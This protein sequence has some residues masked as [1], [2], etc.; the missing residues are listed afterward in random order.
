MKISSG[1]GKF[2]S[3]VLS[4]LLILNQ[5]WAAGPGAFSGTVVEAIDGTTI[6]VRGAQG[7]R[8][9][10]LAGL[11]SESPNTEIGH[12]AKSVLE[13]E[14]LGKNVTVENARANS[15]ATDRIA[16]NHDRSWANGDSAGKSKAPVDGRVFLDGQDIALLLVG[17]G[18]AW[19][20]YNI[21]NDRNLQNSQDEAKKRQEGVWS[22][23]PSKGRPVATFAQPGSFQEEVSSGKKAY[24]ESTK[25][26]QTESTSSLKATE[27]DE[28]SGQTATYK[29]KLKEEKDNPGQRKGWEK[30]K[31]KDELRKR[32]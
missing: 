2:L 14:L 6:K 29:G 10:R 11:E 4:Q 21:L 28:K 26:G 3:V 20:L 15:A 7:D 23:A 16:Q 5:S 12:Q 24:G 22:A 30:Q 32:D 25:S 27:G 18:L 19:L 1:I 31:A 8:L 9:V 13:K 17:A